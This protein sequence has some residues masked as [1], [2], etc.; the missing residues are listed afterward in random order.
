LPVCAEPAIY[1]IGLARNDEWLMHRYIRPRDVICN[2][3][4][5]FLVQFSILDLE[6]LDCRAASE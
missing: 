6:D 2:A 3:L 5:R 4:W 1:Q